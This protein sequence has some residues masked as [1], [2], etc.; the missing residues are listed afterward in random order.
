[1]KYSFHTIKSISN[2]YKSL[3]CVWVIEVSI[4]LSL[5]QTYTYHSHSTH[6]HGVSILLSLFQ[7][8]PN[9]QTWEIHIHVSILLS[10]FQTPSPVDVCSH[11]F[12]VV[13][14][15]LSLFQTKKESPALFFEKKLFP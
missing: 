14:I 1:M 9:G 4:L 10:L 5:F 6:R 13:S 8:Q 7:T 2:F 11:Y 3:Y 15:L 12:L